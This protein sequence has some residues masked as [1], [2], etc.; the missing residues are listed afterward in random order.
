MRVR[1]QSVV[2]HQVKSSPGSWEQ[3]PVVYNLECY[4]FLALFAGMAA[5]FSVTVT[6]TVTAVSTLK[7]YNFLYAED[8]RG[9]L[10][11]IVVLFCCG[12][13]NCNAAD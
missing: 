11:I 7:W 3:G 2:L 9:G 8:G 13:G 10:F 12:G 1:V 4:I 6:V 5:G